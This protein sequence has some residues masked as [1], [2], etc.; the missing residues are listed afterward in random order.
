MIPAIGLENR[1]RRDA[2][3]EA[4]PGGEALGSFFSSVTGSQELLNVTS[5][6]HL[7]SRKS[8]DQ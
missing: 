3:V 1:F 5:I 6:A 8:D 7:R 4:Q 2:V